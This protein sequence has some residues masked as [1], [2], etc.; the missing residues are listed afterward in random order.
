VSADDGAQ[1]LTAVYATVR[2][3]TSE[4]GDG[5]GAFSALADLPPLIRR[6][7]DPYRRLALRARLANCA[8]MVL[9]YDTAVHESRV[10]LRA[11]K[12]LTSHATDLEAWLRWTLGATLSRIGESAAAVVELQGAVELYAEVDDP[13][14]RAEALLELGRALAEQGD[15]ASAQAVLEASL[16]CLEGPWARDAAAQLA[17]MARQRGDLDA[18]IA[19]REVCR[20]EGMA[21]GS[22]PWDLETALGVFTE[23]LVTVLIERGRAADR[24]RA[25]DLLS[26]SIERSKSL[27]SAPDTSPLEDRLRSLEAAAEPEGQSLRPGRFRQRM[28]GR[29]LRSWRLCLPDHK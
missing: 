22:E 12:A 28:P 17:Q 29:A 11:L 23:E 16:K 21:S 14:S 19:A 25:R 27:F 15:D 6:E 10:G 7:R 9:D 3:E 1:M 5:F 26:E 13:E 24:A 2:D 8:F 18:E 4:Y 20:R